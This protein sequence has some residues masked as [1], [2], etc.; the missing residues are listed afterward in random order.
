[1]VKIRSASVSDLHSVVNIHRKAFPDFFLTK[2]GP[3]FL[4][5]MY[6]GYLRHS[7]GIFLVATDGNGVVGFVVGTTL[8]EKFFSE[9]RKQRALSFLVCSIPGLLRNPVLV[10][11]KLFSAIFYRGDEP[12]ELRDGAL[13]SSIG[14]VPEQFGKSIGKKLVAE[15]ERE[16]FSGG[17]EFV[18]LTTDKLNNDRVNQFYKKNGYTI[19][20]SFS[21][22]GNR[23]MLR[24]LKKR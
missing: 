7:S 13:L 17:S 22:V 20:S 18:F 21:Q 1:M 12:E 4:K 15:F 5:E 24:Y 11:K 16:A 14:I 6:S 8:P 3:R 2:M 23:Q 9:L 19:E 10:S